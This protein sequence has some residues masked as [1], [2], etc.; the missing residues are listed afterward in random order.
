MQTPQEDKFNNIKKDSN[1]ASTKSELVAVKTM[2]EK[3]NFV[4]NSVK[5][6]GDIARLPHIFQFL[7]QSMFDKISRLMML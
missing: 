2:L 5:F 1:H 4:L 6:L 3:L 7:F